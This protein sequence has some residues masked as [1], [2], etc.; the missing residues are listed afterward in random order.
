MPYLEVHRAGQ[1]LRDVPIEG[2]QAVV[3]RGEVDVR[4]EADFV[5]RRHARIWAE[6]GAWMIEDLGT[7][8]GTFVNGARE[9]RCVLRDGDR[10]Q[11]DEFILVFRRPEGEHVPQKH[12][13]ETLS[14]ADAR[15]RGV[16]WEPHRRDTEAHVAE[17]Q[18]G[19]RVVDMRVAARK[20]SEAKARLG[21]H[22]KRDDGETIHPLKRERTVVASDRRECDIRI[23]GASRWGAAHLLR[24]E[25]GS[26]LVRWYGL[27]GSVRVDGVKARRHRL[28]GGETLEIHGTHFTFHLGDG[29]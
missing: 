29:A 15:A 7:R 6:Q 27:L 4:L 2:L 26:F 12:V 24:L 16:R 22:L 23:E 14:Q 9:F 18:E 13:G 25:D 3:G 19:T 8:N 5:S 20:R 1:R 28:V 10:V 21:P 17:P 11:V